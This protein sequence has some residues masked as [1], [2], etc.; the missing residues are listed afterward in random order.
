MGRGC[1]LGGTQAPAGSY[2]DQATLPRAV[3]M[4]DRSLQAEAPG[5]FTGKVRI[6][7]GGDYQVAFLLDSPHLVHCFHFTAK[8]GEAEKA[9]QGAGLQVEYLEAPQQVKVGTPFKLQLRAT[10]P[11]TGQ[12]VADLA[13]LLVLASQMG[14]NWSQRYLT[15]SAGEGI[16]EVELT[17][18]YPGL[19]TILLSASSLGTGLDQ[20]PRITLEATN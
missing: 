12:P 6:P 18:P 2:Q 15:A 5:I 8:P 17:L 1:A 11:T 4:V 7:T 9:S 20:L 14:G 13:D 19:Y 3:T 16:Y 10:D